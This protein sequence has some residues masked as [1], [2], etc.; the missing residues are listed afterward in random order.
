[1]LSNPNLKVKDIQLTPAV[2]PRTGEVVTRG[3]N[4]KNIF[5]AK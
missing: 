1:M 4:C 2:R 3:D 5:G